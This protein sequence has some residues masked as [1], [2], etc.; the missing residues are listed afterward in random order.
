MGH[1]RYQEIDSDQNYTH[2]TRNIS[3]IFIYFTKKHEDYYICIRYMMDFPGE[4]SA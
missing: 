2:Y 1:D 4:E 3:F